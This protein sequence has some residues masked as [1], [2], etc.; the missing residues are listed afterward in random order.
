MLVINHFAFNN[1]YTHVH[2]ALVVSRGAVVA[3]A[4]HGV[5]RRHIVARGRVVPWNVV[6]GSVLHDA[7]Q[8]DVMMLA[9]IH[10]GH[11]IYSVPAGVLGVA[12]R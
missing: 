3:M 11:Y 7:H 6:A 12:R 9:S 1:S 10:V 2:G 5:A 4:R 8:V